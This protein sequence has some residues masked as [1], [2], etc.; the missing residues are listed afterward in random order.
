MSKVSEAFRAEVSEWVAA[1]FP[2]ALKNNPPPFE[3][4]VDE[5]L[6]ADYEL[7]RSRLAQQGWGAPTWA[8][9]YGGAGLSHPE[10]KVVSREIA[11]AG[12]FNHI[13]LLAGMGVTMVGPTILEY[14][15][16]AQKARHLPGICLLYTSPSPRDATLSRMPSSA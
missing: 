14:G 3:G 8:R 12:G 6:K 15:T 5:A 9:E 7:W 2:S 10:A 4:A 1:N 13:P 11:R 16:D